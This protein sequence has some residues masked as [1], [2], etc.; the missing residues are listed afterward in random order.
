MI[1]I[2]ITSPFRHKYENAD[3]EKRKDIFFQAGDYYHLDNKESKEEVKQMLSPNYPFKNYIY[4]DPS[5]VPQEISKELNL[6]SGF[7]KE[8]TL[9]PEEEYLVTQTQTG[10]MPLV[11]DD[12]D[13]PTLEPQKNFFD[14]TSQPQSTAEDE[15]E[16]EPEAEAEA[17][18]DNE[19]D[20][21]E[22]ADKTTVESELETR[23]EELDKLHYRKLREIASI[24]GVEYTNKQE[25][26]KRIIELEY[27]EEVE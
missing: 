14:M 27:E 10:T 6:E 7:Y 5:T 18:F 2:Q 19:A 8:Y 9:P 24:Y 4:V 17:V 21:K 15:P 25:V 26:I 23:K 3:R 13:Q 16:P 22:Q 20:V 1:R 12:E 11:A